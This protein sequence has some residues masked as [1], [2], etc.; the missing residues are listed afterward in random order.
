MSEE[1]I[2]NTDSL[3]KRVVESVIEWLRFEGRNRIV[4]VPREVSDQFFDLAADL[5]ALIGSHPELFGVERGK[6]FMAE[7]E[8]TQIS[9]TIGNVELHFAAYITRAPRSY[10][11]FGTLELE[12]LRA[13]GVET[14]ER[15][16][17][18]KDQHLSWQLQRYGS[19]N[20]KTETDN[21]ASLGLALKLEWYEEKLL[22]KLYSERG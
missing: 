14:P 6:R 22:E 17:L 21:A 20:Y 15:I 5:D 9:V 3:Q 1:F 12:V 18:I 16:V 10:D 7:K 2:E 8:A 13:K 11:G 19:G 4:S